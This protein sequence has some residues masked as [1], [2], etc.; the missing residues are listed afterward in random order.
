MSAAAGIPEEHGE[1][2][3]SGIIDVQGVP[4]RPLTL[5]QFLGWIDARL[6]SEE[7]AYV[8][9]VNASCVVQASRDPAFMR[10][11]R[12]SAVN[13]PD[14]KP[15]AL[16]VSWL[17]RVRQPRLP[18]PDVMLEVLQRASERRYRVLLYGSTEET[19]AS[20][21]KRL[22]AAYPGV[23][24]AESVSPPFRPLTA[25]EEK[26]MCEHIRNADPD[27][28]FVG[29][30]APKQELWMHSHS[31]EIGGVMM[32]V[33]AAFDFHSGRVRRASPLIQRLGLEWAHR[34][35]QEPRRLWA[36]YMTTLPVFA[37]RL[38]QQLV[39]GGRT[40]R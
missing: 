30:G 24:L 8:C 9:A 16:A 29:L 40:R 38:L 12:E 27:L 28:V 39:A 23:V 6:A 26:R 13:L 10:A 31:D 14:G 18:G 15:V 32:G 7:P 5:Q 37:W 19:L 21:E 22:R 4:F 1:S 17:G 20:L 36:R 2:G 25:S 3:A 35:I 34:I 11:L 33:G